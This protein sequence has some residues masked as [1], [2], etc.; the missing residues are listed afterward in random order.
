MTFTK[1]QKREVQIMDNENQS[2]LKQACIENIKENTRIEVSQ[3]EIKYSKWY[4]RR[5][6]RIQREMFKSDKLIYPEVDNVFE[7][8]R[9]KIVCWRNEYGDKSHQ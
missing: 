6:N 9:S 1:C 8:A 4:K 2:V 3:K 7:R 5:I